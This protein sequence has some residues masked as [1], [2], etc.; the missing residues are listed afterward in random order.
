[1]FR[2]IFSR[3]FEDDAADPKPQWDGGAGSAVVLVG[4]DGLI[5]ALSAGAPGMLGPEAKAGAALESLFPVEDRARLRRALSLGS[6]A[7]PLRL[8]PVGAL[9]PLEIR[10]TRRPDGVIALLLLETSTEERGDLLADLGHE[11]RTPLNAIIGF[12]DAMAIETYGALGHP[13]YV[14]YAEIIRGSGRH[15]LDLVSSI[16]DLKKIEAGAYKLKRERVDVGAIVRECAALIRGEVEKAGL[17][18]VVSVPENLPET[19]ADPRA[20]RQVLIN[21]LSNAVKFTPEGEI[22]LEAKTAGGDLVFIV[23]DTGVG[24]NPAQLK[25]LG[26]RYAGHGGDGVRGAKGAGLGLNIA[27]ALVALHE[28]KMDIASA[29]GEGVRAEIRLPI[30]AS[31]RPERRLRAVNADAA[32]VSAQLDDGPALRHAPRPVVVSQLERIEAYRRERAKSAA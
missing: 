26:A 3:L 15:L 18:L 23:A 7:K 14:E 31:A 9:A 29:P 2:T 5:T 21:L 24:M 22:T 20:L 12:S 11:M 32:E 8:Q 17:R 27:F 19:S 16:L 1:M 6:A 28:G 10:I 13:K 25:R 4:A 30:L